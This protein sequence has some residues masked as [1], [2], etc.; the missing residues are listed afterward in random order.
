MTKIPYVT[1]MKHAQRVVKNI[2]KTRPVLGGVMHRDGNLIVTDTHRLYIAE[3]A[4]DGADKL[5]N[6]KTG[7]LIDGNYP[8]VS[9]LIPGL[10]DAKFSAKINVDPAQK[11][12]KLI[13]QAGKIDK[14]TDLITIEGG[15]THTIFET[16]EQSLVAV[17]YGA[18]AGNTDE[19]FKLTASAKYISEAFAL[20]KDAGL[21]EVTF[22]FH[23]N[24]RPFTF[25][26]GNLTVLIL[27]VRTY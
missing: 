6:P 12:V 27:P 10:N 22:N 13:E 24:M 8:D 26:G 1:F 9:R 19:V 18:D 14:A 16:H 7:E 17:E 23:G 21:T 5:E 25:T 11:A 4:Y 3:G 20:L 15:G 2:G